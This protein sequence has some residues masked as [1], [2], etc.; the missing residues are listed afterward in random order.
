MADISTGADAV[1]DERLGYQKLNK[2]KNHYYGAVAPANPVAGVIW[3]DSDDGKVYRYYGAAWVEI[4]SA[5]GFPEG[6]IIAWVGGYFGDGSNG[7]YANVLAGANTV[8]ATN[9]LLNA[10]GWYVCDGAALNLGTSTIFNGASRYL[11]NLTD[12]RFI[13]GDTVIATLGGDSAMAHTHTK[14]SFAVGSHNHIGPVGS[15]YTVPA[16]YVDQTYGNVQLNHARERLTADAGST[17]TANV[18]YEYTASSTPS[19]GGTSSAASETENRP[20]FLSCFYLMYV[21]A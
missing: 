11:P 4:A 5:A 14:G 16:M 2:L 17:A 12:D 19:F 10:D 15:A 20:K 3:I 8:A 21:L 9:A 6:T 18:W 7:S 13:M 1:V